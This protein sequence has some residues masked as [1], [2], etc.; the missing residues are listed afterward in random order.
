LVQGFDFH[1]YPEKDENGRDMGYHF[2]GKY[3]DIV[4]FN[5]YNYSCNTRE[6]A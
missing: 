3:A 4:S 6:A 5:R 2:G 1:F